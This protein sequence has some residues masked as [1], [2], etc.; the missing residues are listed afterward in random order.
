MERRKHI[1][2]KQRRKE[3]RH[4]PSN[5]ETQTKEKHIGDIMQTADDIKPIK[6]SRK[7]I[8]GRP[9]KYTPE[10]IRK[11]K[12][13]IEN[14]EQ[15]GD[16]IPSIAGLS[17][18]LDIARETLQVWKN[19]KNKSE[20]SNIIK[21]LSAAQERK[22]LNGG[23]NSSLNSTITKLVLSKHGYTENNSNNQGNSGIT[24]QVNRSGVVLKSGGQ[25]LEVQADDTPGRTIEHDQTDTEAV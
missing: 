3:T 4:D 8:G 23:L 14:Y 10:V 19:D 2:A 1:L 5:Q 6:K 17:Q 11:A 13:Y 15:Y 18:E 16:S 24:V 20:F 25:T 12:D 22:L 21:A 7:G 9:S